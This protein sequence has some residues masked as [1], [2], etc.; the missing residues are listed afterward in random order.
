MYRYI[1]QFSTYLNQQKVSNNTH[2][3]YVHDVQQYVTYLMQHGVQEIFDIQQQHVDTFIAYL[4]SLA[5]TPATAQRKCASLRAFFEFCARLDLVV[6]CTKTTLPIW[7]SYI[8]AHEICYHL[9]QASD[10]FKRRDAWIIHIINEYHVSFTSVARTR[11]SQTCSHETG[12]VYAQIDNI[13]I[14]ITS[15]L[16][17]VHPHITKN[18]DNKSILFP[19]IRHTEPIVIPRNAWTQRLRSYV[20]SH[21][22]SPQNVFNNETCNEADTLHKKQ[23]SQFH[24]RA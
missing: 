16:Y 11:I 8:T 3:A 15:Y 10:P 6:H 4:E 7:C 24:E 22:R 23:Y 21:T 12:L 14:D 19:Y 1:T 2:D 17:N 5:I 13:M 9:H 18:Q 20:L